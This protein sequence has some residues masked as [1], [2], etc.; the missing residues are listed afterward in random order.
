MLN[1]TKH[2]SV[3]SFQRNQGLLEAL[4]NFLIY[5]KLKSKGLD[6][7]FKAEKIEE[8]KATILLFLKQLN[9]VV[10]EDNN[11]EAP[12]TRLLGLDTR[13]KSLVSQFNE[14]KG[15]KRR[16][17]SVLFRQNPTPVIQMLNKD[18]IGSSKEL[19]DSLTELGNLIEDHLS[20]DTREVIGDI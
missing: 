6:S 7:K 17:K 18:E 4:N 9:D 1:D 20:T 3:Q 10:S 15:K 14:A 8:A 2:L 11:M 16:F 13:F 12:S 5:L 19:I